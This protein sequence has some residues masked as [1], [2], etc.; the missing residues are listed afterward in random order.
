MPLLRA[1][2]RFMGGGQ[3][4]TYLLRDLFTTDAAAPLATPRT[5]DPGPGTL[6]LVQND[7]E[8]STTG[9]KL[10]LVAQAT[11]TNGDQALFGSTTRAAGRLFASRLNKNALG[12]NAG[13]GFGSG[14]AG[15]GYDGWSCVSNLWKG[16]P[17]DV[18]LFLALPL[19]DYDL[20][21]LLMATGA[22]LVQRVGPGANDWVIHY[23]ERLDSTANISH[24]YVNN[25]PGTLDNYVLCDVGGAWGQTYGHATAYVATP[26]TGQVIA[27]ESESHIELTW[28]PAANETLDVQF[29]RTDDDNCWLLRC[30][31]AAGTI[32]LFDKTGGVETEVDAG[33]TQTW[34]VATAY[35]VYIRVWA[36]TIA[37]YVVNVPKHS[38]TAA[39]A[40]QTATGAK[41]SGFATAADFVAT[42]YRVQIPNPGFS[43]STYFWAYGDSKTWGTG[44]S[45]GVAGSNGYPP[46]LGASAGMV[47]SVERPNL[48]GLT[49][50]N[51]K[52]RVDADLLRVPG[53]QPR[54]CLL[55]FGANDASAMPEEAAFKTNYL[56]IIDALR[57]KWPNTRVGLMRA[58]KRNEDA[59]C[60][61][62]AGW[63]GDVVA[64]RSFCFLG[65]D[66]RV[67]LKGS[68]NGVT[69][70]TD[71]IHPNHAGY[72]LTAAQ[73]QAAM[74][75]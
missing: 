74:G 59:D 23:I 67:F 69:Y 2:S 64:L 10:A 36:S 19:I 45:E 11:Y 1:G 28:T 30:D 71:G 34:T 3:R 38:Y 68:D 37:T 58:W 33:K 51:A 47:E 72:V 14:A 4:V 8:F 55:N 66:E 32:K 21:V 70:T 31:Q 25:F 9:G 44:D 27:T 20:G 61:T 7:G 13:F 17:V 63:I 62:L 40:R 24:R 15:A 35:R 48:S 52:A 56:Y 57:A 75:L 16:Y 54:Y 39:L 26:A 42:P 53:W 60:D 43:T 5:C 50:A 73:W 12:G 18:T 22:Y 65:P 49:V 41:A 6:T 29:R 46:L